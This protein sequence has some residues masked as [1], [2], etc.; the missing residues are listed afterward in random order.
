MC[1][2]HTARETGRSLSQMPATDDCKEQQ[3]RLARLRAAYL[4][5]AAHRAANPLK[6]LKYRAAR[7][8]PAL[9][10]EILTK[11]SAHGTEAAFDAFIQ[12]RFSNSTA[13]A[14]AAAPPDNPL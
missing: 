13:A 4:Q 7:I 6:K 2:Q 14:A 10:Q 3:R 8:G 11:F 12:Q 1:Q 5:A 9:A